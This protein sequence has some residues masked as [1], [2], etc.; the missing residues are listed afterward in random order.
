MKVVE[1]KDP[2]KTWTKS[3]YGEICLNKPKSNQ[4]LYVWTKICFSI[5][6]V[7]EIKD[8]SKTLSDLI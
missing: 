1:I 7:V 5:V 8:P 4:Y 3:I 2:S 6:R